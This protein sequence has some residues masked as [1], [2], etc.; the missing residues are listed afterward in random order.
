M[1]YRIYQYI[2]LDI[3][4]ILIYLYSVIYRLIDIP[5]SICHPYPLFITCD[6]TQNHCRITRVLHPKFWAALTRALLFSS[7]N[8]LSIHLMHTCVTFSDKNVFY[9][10]VGNFDIVFIYQ[11]IPNFTNCEP[12]VT[13]KNCRHCTSCSSVQV[14]LGWP[15]LSSLWMFS[16]LS[17][18]N[19]C[20]HEYTVHSSITF[21]LYPFYNSLCMACVERFLPWENI[22]QS[23]LHIRWTL[24]M[25]TLK[26]FSYWYGSI[27]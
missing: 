12:S 1:I 21:T 20:T 13:F 4:D 15:L 7:V 23:V 10:H 22:S 9:G 11:R 16:H 18:W 26:N 3:S 24:V 19:L 6:D 5:L 17:L 2:T 25:S 14:L 27:F 8:S